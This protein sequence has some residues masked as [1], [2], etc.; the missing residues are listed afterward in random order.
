MIKKIK[1][2]IYFFLLINLCILIFLSSVK[3]FYFEESKVKIVSSEEKKLNETPDFV[4]KENYIHLVWTIWP[5]EYESYVYYKKS[6]DSGKTWIEE[7]LISSNSTKALYPTITKNDNSIH[8]AWIDYRDNVSEIY[9][10][11]SLNE[12]NSFLAPKRITYNSSRKTYIYDISI[13]A[14]DQDIYLTWKD[15]RYGS[16]EIFFKKSSNNGYSWSEDLRLTADYTPS[17]F[18]TLKFNKKNI[19]IFYEDWIDRS[20]ITL[21]KSNDNGENWNEKKWITKSIISEDS[22][23]PDSYISDKFIYLVFQNDNTG[24]NQIYFMKSM[25]YGDNWGKIKQITF[26]DLGSIR[27]RI[28]FNS[29]RL[30]V[31]WTEVINNLNQIF[32]INSTDEGDSWSEPKKLDCNHNFHDLSFLEKNENTY[33]VWQ[34]YHEPCWA[35]ICFYNSFINLSEENGKNEE[36]IDESPG[37]NLVLTLLLIFLTAIF[38]KIKIYKGKR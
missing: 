34:N 26:S 12:G 32:Y 25:N 14:N 24:K 5:T 20:T 17:Y 18:P 29:N 10:T 30:I 3:A 23:N 8:I 38:I 19:L 31:F 36:I 35:D 11:R 16:S 7:K 28:S 13:N 33:L 21:L 15:Y 37:F 6:I 1:K 2:F 27:P 4:V 9:Y 22:I